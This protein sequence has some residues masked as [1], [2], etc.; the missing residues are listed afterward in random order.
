MKNY[1]IILLL[2]VS[3]ISCSKS[4]PKT[5]KKPNVVM[6]CVDDMNDY[7]VKNSYP[8]VIAPNIQKL[9]ERGI[10]F[11]NAAANS[12][13]C[14][15]SRTSFFSGIYA[16]KTGAYYNDSDGWNRSEIL[17]KIKSIPE[18]FKANGYTTFGR[19]KIFHNPLDSAREANMWD[20]RPIYKGGFKPFGSAENQYGNRFFSIQPWTGPDTDFPDVLNAT[21]SIEF[22][23]QKHDKP[24][25]LYFGLWRPHNPYTAPKRFF[26]LYK[27]N[28]ISFPAS[29][30]EDDL[31][32]VPELGKMLSDSL[33]KFRSNSNDFKKLWKKFI[34]AYCANYSFADWNVGRVIDALDNSEYAENTIV[35]F[36]SDNGFHTGQ[37]LR[38][39]KAT[40]WDQADYVPFIIRTPSSNGGICKATVSLIDIYPT[41]VDYCNLTPPTH[42]L[43][44]HSIVPLLKDKNYKWKYP[45]ISMYGEHYS[46][47]RTENYR[48]IQY[49]D[50]TDEFY[51]H[52]ID[53]Y[54]FN[55]SVGDRKYS[56]IIN[57]MQK[58]IPKRW[59][60]STGGRLEVPRDFTK[61]M[62]NRSKFDK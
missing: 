25:L 11:I 48:Y 28:E 5:N 40:L 15:P 18:L 7:A 55:N 47:I 29:I 32:D 53:P 9:K 3:V 23:K 8:T 2:I 57:N 33:N 6:I 56:R 17:K 13:V 30:K 46:S 50:K 61:V 37:K 44:G 20:N 22:L 1:I 49:P 12:P 4:K 27:E 10:N 16:Y 60:N 54:E 39:G 24:F 62:R 43:D 45:S 42:N 21:A 26:D 58:Y 36:F 41:L 35:I 19:G 59:E 51:D 14:N 52:T 38:W 31:S 34:Y